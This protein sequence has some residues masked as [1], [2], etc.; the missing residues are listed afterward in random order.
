VANAGVP[1]IVRA[2]G[3]A[4]LVGDVVLNCTGGYPAMFVD[5]LVPGTVLGPASIP[6]VNVQIF[7]NTNIT[8]RLS[9]DGVSSEAL[10]MID[11]PRD[12]EQKICTTVLN[13]TNACVPNPRPGDPGNVYKP[14]GVGETT[15][16]NYNVW[17]GRQAQPNSIVWLGVPIDA[18]GAPTPICSACP[19]RWFRRTSSCTSRSP[20]PRRFQSTTRRRRWPGSRRG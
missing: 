19:R 1:P 6:Q 4:E 5:P 2:E 3:L 16:N 20:V 14:N 8:S 12:A 7:L 15:A 17:Q 9:G 11:D 10:L 18:P 13:A